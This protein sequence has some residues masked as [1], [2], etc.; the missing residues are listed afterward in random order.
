MHNIY[1]LPIETRIR[2]KLYIYIDVRCHSIRHANIHTPMYKHG[3]ITKKFTNAA[4]FLLNTHQNHENGRTTINEHAIH[5][6]NR[7]HNYIRTITFKVEFKSR[8]NAS[9][10]YLTLSLLCCFTYLLTFYVY[11]VFK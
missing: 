7:L 2:F 1:W 10:R 3:R 9:L 4:Y 6:W 11:K 5:T 8:L